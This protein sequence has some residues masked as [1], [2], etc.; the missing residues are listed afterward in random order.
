M[1]KFALILACMLL[2][3][4]LAYAGPIG[5]SASEYDYAFGGGDTNYHIAFTGGE[6]SIVLVSGD[7]SSVLDV[8]IYDEAG[9][10]VA[11]D[12]GTLAGSM[13]VWTPAYT[14]NYT[15]LVF[16]EGSALNVY[17]LDIV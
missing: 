13:V 10:L 7:G 1:K 9:N 15:V 2:A 8:A 5:G 14:G 11:Y 12:L 16:N 3:A 4:P 17:S 6:T